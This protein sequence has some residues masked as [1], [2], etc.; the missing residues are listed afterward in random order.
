MDDVV[1]PLQAPTVRPI[2]AAAVR[3]LLHGFTRK[4]VRT[5]EQGDYFYAHEC[6]Y[7][8]SAT[9]TWVRRNEDKPHRCPCCHAVASYDRRTAGPRTRMVCPRG[10]GV[11][12]RYGS[13]ATR[14]LRVWRK[15]QDTGG[16]LDARYPRFVDGTSIG[17]KRRGDR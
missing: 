2:E 9:P 1:A 11:Q 3:A 16:Y 8:L 14:D 17:R 15:R 13:R 6:E 10:C 5:I 4:P 7:P 12:W